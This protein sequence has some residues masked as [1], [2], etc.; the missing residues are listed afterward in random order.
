MATDYEKS[1]DAL[2]KD[3]KELR[4]D[5]KAVVEALKE[6]A[7]G[8][9]GALR[10]RGEETVKRGVARLHEAAES[11]KER[12]CNIHEHLA[13]AVEEKPVLTVLAALGVGVLLGE[14]LSWRRHS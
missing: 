7:K 4:A 12:G 5:M 11:L 9:A 14:I 8:E 13:A 10:D 3:V 1:I 2:Y 6:S